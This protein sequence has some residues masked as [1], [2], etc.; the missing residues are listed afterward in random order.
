MSRSLS[1]R[2]RWSIATTCCCVRGPL[3]TSHVGVV[4][5]GAGLY[6]DAGGG[7]FMNANAISDLGFYG[8]HI[9]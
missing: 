7:E 9:R 8:G 4:A 6:S 2:F 3:I 1:G 5:L